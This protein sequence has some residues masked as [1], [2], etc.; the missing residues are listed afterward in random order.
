[1]K[2]RH[3]NSAETLEKLFKKLELVTFWGNGPEIWEK[4]WNKFYLDE[5]NF[6]KINLHKKKR[7]WED[8]WENFKLILKRLEGIF[9]KIYRK[10]I[11]NF[12]EMLK[13]IDE[14]EISGYLENF[15]K[16]SGKLLVKIKNIL[17]YIWDNFKEI[18]GTNRFSK[19]CASVSN[20]FLE[21]FEELLK[22]QLFWVNFK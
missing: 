21:H 13:N 14:M 2:K 16:K 9:V 7:N 12:G 15:W 18:I 11:A 8:F 10:F 4:F 19:L 3:K 1:M 5:R 22:Q 17:Y 20:K 6:Y